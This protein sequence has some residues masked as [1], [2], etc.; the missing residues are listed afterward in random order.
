MK[1]L[2]RSLIAA[3]A[4]TLAFS[5]PAFAG[6]WQKDG[7]GW[8]YREDDGSYPVNGWYWIDGDNDGT[9]ECY[10]FDK[11]GYMV[12]NFG[13][14]EGYT[15]ND[16]GAW[17]VRGVVQTKDVTV[18]NDPAAEALLIAANEK[19]Q[20]QDLDADVVAKTVMSVDGDTGTM[21]M[22]VNIKAKNLT[23]AS[24]EMVMSGTVEIDG[25]S[26]PF[27]TFYKDGYSYTDM[28]DMKIK[29]KSEVEEAMQITDMPA[30]SQVDLSSISNLKMREEGGKKILTYEVLGG[31]LSSTLNNTVEDMALAEETG[32]NFDYDVR[33]AHGEYMIDADGNMVS[34]SV[35]MDFSIAVSYAGEDEEEP[36]S[37]A[38]GYVMDMD[39]VINNPGKPVSIK[40]PPTEG[41]QSI[42]EL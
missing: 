9:A 26:V 5:V 13:K 7:K 16:D 14:I 19:L 18:P 8:W 24:P 23:G 22:N 4:M 42:E 29:Q 17:V 38:I 12:E 1:K 30:A 11:A 2:M 33:N 6:E 34:E 21:V 37:L 27:S 28:M 25:E 41:Y 40:F 10:Y 3:A 39:A 15:V 32:L 31:K 35:H 36:D 20:T